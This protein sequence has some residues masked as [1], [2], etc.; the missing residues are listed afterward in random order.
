MLQIKKRKDDVNGYKDCYNSSRGKGGKASLQNQPEESGKKS[1]ASGSMNHDCVKGKQ[2]NT[3]QIGT[4]K[5]HVEN[6]ADEE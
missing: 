2:E 1:P 5:E 6:A 3:S 4:A